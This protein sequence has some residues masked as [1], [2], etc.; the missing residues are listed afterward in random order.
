M[1]REA[2]V[3]HEHL[4]FCSGINKDIYLHNGKKIGNQLL[5][6]YKNA[7][8]GQTFTATFQDTTPE[9]SNAY[10]TIHPKYVFNILAG[11]RKS[12]FVIEV[13]VILGIVAYK[14]DMR[15]KV[16]KEEK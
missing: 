11:G 4:A 1:Y 5:E 9:N 16:K 14:F 15:W 3:E 12:D 6:I 13:N 10:Y 8:E 7:D 2:E